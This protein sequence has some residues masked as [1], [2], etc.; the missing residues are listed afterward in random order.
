MKPSERMSASVQAC[1]HFVAEGLQIKPLSERTCFIKRMGFYS[2]AF[3]EKSSVQKNIHT[4]SYIFI[5]SILRRW[6]SDD[7][8]HEDDL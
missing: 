1:T 4:I 5:W 7:K 8:A 2:T 3:N 6:S